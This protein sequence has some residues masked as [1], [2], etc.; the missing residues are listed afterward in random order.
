VPGR[1][2]EE[3]AEPV[4]VVVGRGEQPDL[5]LAHRARPGVQGADVQAAAELRGDHLP[6]PD[7]FTDIPIIEASFWLTAAGLAR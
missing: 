5:L 3:E 7:V 6:Q 4:Q 2:G 1:G